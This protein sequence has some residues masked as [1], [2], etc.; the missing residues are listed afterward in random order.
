MCSSYYGE[1]FEPVIVEDIKEEYKKHGEEFVQGRIK[2]IQ[3]N[4]A[5]AKREKESQPGDE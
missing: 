5:K 1:V 2:I 3:D 4:V